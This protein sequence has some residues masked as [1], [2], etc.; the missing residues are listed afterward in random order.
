MVIHREVLDNLKG[1]VVVE[2]GG[3]IE[4]PNPAA[5]RILGLEAG[6]AAGRSLAELFILRRGF[7][8]FTQL[9]IDATTTDAVWSSCEAAAT[10]VNPNIPRWIRSSCADDRSLGEDHRT[11]GPFHTWG[12]KKITT[13]Q[14]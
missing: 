13:P 1:G 4:T 7:H 14:Y 8:D 3:R 2:L 6:E 5:E 9:V 12:P 11:M 10:R